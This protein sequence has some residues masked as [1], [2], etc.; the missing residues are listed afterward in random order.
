MKKEIKNLKEAAERIKLAVKNDERIIIYG[1]SDCDGICSVVILEETIKN[2]GGKV[3]DVLFP[4]REKDGY[5]INLKALELIKDKAPALFITLD[6]GIGNIKEVKIANKYGFSVIIVDHH[7]IL[8]SIPEA[9]I[10]VNPQQK[11]D[12]SEY[13]YLANVGLTFLLCR[14][15]LGDNISLN[16]K[17]SFLELA[18]LATISDMVPQIGDNKM[19]I[20]EGLRSLKNTFRPALRAFLDIIGEGEVVGTGLYKLIAAINAAE[21]VDFK[22][23]GYKLMTESSPKKAM[24]LAQFL[25]D[26]TAFKQIKIKEITEEVE[27]RILKKP[28]SE[29]I[30]E[31][32]PAWK[33]IWAG[34]VA[35]IL[36]NK[37]NKPTFVFRKGDTESAGS[38]RSPKEKNSVE[39]MKS[40]AD[41][42]ITYG[43]HPQASGFRVKNENLEKFKNGL[44]DYFSKL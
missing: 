26:K 42:L 19:F 36:Y 41:L 6:L 25:I 7:Q 9:E 12:E 16:L 17:N 40:C 39:A 22:N 30:F 2:L 38:V 10:V 4:D 34:S 8:S 20:E 23:E 29:I 37:Y 3:F 27:R 31:G 28:A 18:A 13:K 11:D 15:I 43:G 1:D 32:D 5:G 33:L 14:E 24:E 44:V 21:S 35:S